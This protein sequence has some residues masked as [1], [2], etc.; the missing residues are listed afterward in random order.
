MVELES[1]VTT[2]VDEGLGNSSYLV[3]L[4]D[5]GALAVDPPRDLAPSGRRGEGRVRLL[6]RRHP[7]A[8]RFPLRWPRSWPPARRQVLA[9]AAGHPA[10]PHPRPGRRRR[11]RPR[12]LIAARAGP[13][14]GIPTSTCPTCSWTGR[15]RSGCSPAARCWPA[16]RRAP[17]SRR[18]PRPRSWPAPSSGRCSAPHAAR[19]DRGVAH[20]RGR[21]VLLGPA[22]RRP[23]HHHR[24]G[25][26]RQPAAGRARRGRLRPRLLAP[27]QL[28]A[29]TSPASREVTAA[30]LPCSAR[31][32]G[33][34]PLTP[35]AGPRPPRRGGQRPSTCARSP[36]S[37]RV[38]S[39][40]RCRY[41]CARRSRPGWAGWSRPTRPFIFRL[42]VPARTA[43]RSP[44]RRT[45]SATSGLAG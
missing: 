10:F 40:A 42:V 19:R 23:H 37:P 43:P 11:G 17:T 3:D 4:G 27:G 13:P 1:L 31:P 32:P 29:P 16:R 15:G 7:P 14:P 12:R 21:V 26:G 34:A 36:P 24:R 2:V 20:S 39:P 8:R 18:R 25:A 30:G 6:R 38:T 5:G 33:L 9:A 35:A 45:R 28:P 44:A 22:R 41:R